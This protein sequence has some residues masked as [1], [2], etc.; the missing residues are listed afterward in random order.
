ML[1]TI[2]TIND[3][4]I[5]AILSSVIP[6]VFS[7][8][9]VRIIGVIIVVFV[10]IVIINFIENNVVFIFLLWAVIEEMV[11]CSNSFSRTK[12]SGSS[13]SKRVIGVY[14]IVAIVTQRVSR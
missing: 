9:V 12:Y 4:I 3:T 8:F 14:I 7:W 2:T 6:A 1:A 11:G 13:L 10:D 5:T